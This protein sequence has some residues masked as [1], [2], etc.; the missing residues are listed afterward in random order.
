MKKKIKKLYNIVFQ[1]TLTARL[2]FMNLESGYLYDIGWIN[3]FKNKMPMDRNC[4]PLPWVTYSFMEFIYERLDCKMDI[5]EF[6]AG[7]S[8]L[9]YASKVNTVTSVEHDQIWYK[10]IQNDMPANVYINYEALIYH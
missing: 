2:F 3:S 7:N 5:F 8:T 10:K 4:N 9:W 1:P 6:G